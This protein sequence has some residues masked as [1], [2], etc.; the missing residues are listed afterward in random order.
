M[1]MFQFALH[2][3]EIHNKPC[4][5]LLSSI[6]SLRL[7]RNTCCSSSVTPSRPSTVSRVWY[8]KHVL[9]RTLMASVKRAL[10][11]LSSTIAI[12]QQVNFVLIQFFSLVVSN[13]MH[14]CICSSSTTAC[15]ARSFILSCSKLLDSFTLNIRSLHGGYISLLNNSIASDQGAP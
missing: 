7:M 9:H 13:R 15:H 11:S 8:L 2:T 10:I 14:S 5:N 3:D 4:I 12:C 1:V 6:V